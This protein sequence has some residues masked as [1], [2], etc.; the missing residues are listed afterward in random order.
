[1][2]WI[3]P[4]PLNSKNPTSWRLT[5]RV[6]DGSGKIKQVRIC[7]YYSSAEAEVAL[8]KLKDFKE[9]GIDV[10]H[11]KAKLPFREYFEDW[12]KQFGC[13]AA[14][15]K[16]VT[17][18]VIRAMLSQ[19]NAAKALM[20][21]PLSKI[22][23]A[24]ITKYFAARREMGIND[25]TLRRQYTLIKNVFRAC[26]EE[27]HIELASDPTQRVKAP[28]ESPHR[29]RRVSK[30]EYQKLIALAHKRRAGY[31]P[32]VIEFALKTA[33]RVGEIA[34]ARLDNVNLEKRTLFLPKTKNGESRTVLLTKRAVEIIEIARERF[35]KDGLI[36]GASVSA[37]KQAWRRML[38]ED[39]TIADL[40]FHDIRHER[41]SQL[42][43]KGK[44]RVP[45]VQMITGHKNQA[46]LARYTHLDVGHVLYM[47]DE[48][49]DER[50]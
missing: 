16:T 26:R 28:K 47:L 6:P 35:A 39:G 36:F 4:Y 12:E 29:T 9:A 20:D 49:D 1:M 2:P 44:M 38:K 40:H 13:K 18:F 32:Y 30:S 11:E 33:M 42:F 19:D 17:K 10:S 50:D 24:D 21:K 37:I 34:T 23:P 5:D 43:E 48:A 41:A 3:Q 8:K 14:S 46:S 27:W 15:Y 22:T 31:L 7:T 45:H 25:S